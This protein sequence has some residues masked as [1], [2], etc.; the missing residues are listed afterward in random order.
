MFFQKFPG[1]SF[2]AVEEPAVSWYNR[3]VP[4]FSGRNMNGSMK[5]ETRALCILLLTA[6]IW[7]FA[8]S[9]QKTG[10]EHLPVFTFGAWR[11]LA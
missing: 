1:D 5:K 6:A 10:A 2:G 4:V 7:G 9:A 3:K 11:Y 8:F